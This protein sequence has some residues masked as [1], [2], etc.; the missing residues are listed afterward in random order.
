MK[1]SFAQAWR[2][3]RLL[4]LIGLIYDVFAVAQILHF[5][6]SFAGLVGWICLALR[7]VTGLTL[8][9]LSLVLA[10]GF[11]REVGRSP[12]REIAAYKAWLCAYFNGPVFAGAVIGFIACFQSLFFIMQKATIRF[13]NPYHWDATFAGIDEALHFGRYPG[14]W[15]LDAFGGGRFD[16][17]LQMLYVGWFFYMYVALGFALFC[18]KSSVLRFRFVSCYVLGWYLLGGLAATYFSSAGPVFF[19]DIYPELPPLYERLGAYLAAHKESLSPFFFLYDNLLMWYRHKAQLVPNAPSAMPSMHAATSTLIALYAFHHGRV[20]FAVAVLMGLGIVTS[21]IYFGFH[22][23]IDSYVSILA[24][25][26][27]WWGTGRVF[28]R[29]AEN[30]PA[31]ALS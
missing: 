9:F 11:L 25:G 30:S 12:G 17:L 31:G 15:L 18:E 19:H 1:Q 4:L 20:L 27:I 26:G 6:L 3:Y 28:R 16:F 29:R 22:Y 24:M 5:G 2:D 8:L 7:H 23:A 10:G 14:D 21:S 13:A